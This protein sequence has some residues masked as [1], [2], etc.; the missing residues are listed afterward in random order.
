MK[1]SFQLPASLR[2]ALLGL[3]LFLLPL[4]PR[5]PQLSQAMTGV[6][7]A[8][9]SGSPGQAARLLQV[10]LAY[11]PWR[12]ELWLAAGRYA[13][14][15]GDLQGTV[16]LLEKAVSYQRLSAPDALLLGDAYRQLGK[17]PQAISAWERARQAGADPLEVTQRLLQVHQ[18]Q[19]DLPALTLDLQTLADLQPGNARAQYQ[20]GLSLSAQQPSAAVPYLERA[21]AL[22][23]GLL[24]L[25]QPLRDAIQAALLVDDPAY[26]LVEAGRKLAALEEWRL[27]E[28][29]FQN[30]VQLAPQNGEAWAFLAEARQHLDPPETQLAKQA[31]DRALQASPETVL[32]RILASLYWQRQGDDL[33]AQEH[34]QEALRLEPE[35]PVLYVEI[36][37]L[38]SRQGELSAA[39][40]AFQKAVDLDPRQVSYRRT[41]V[42]FLL[43]HQIELRESALPVARQAVLLAPRDP[44]ALDLMGETLF[45]L[46]DY[47]TAARFVERALQED[48]EYAPALLHLG[49]ISLY[50]GDNTKARLLMTRARDL[51]GDRLTLNQAE[52]LLEYYFP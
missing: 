17:D 10:V 47:H 42:E 32:V 3:L 31:L 9:K 13:A 34:L 14:Q 4:S 37:S 19:D 24:R 38:L 27:A 28:A 26:R 36:G 2:L 8:V 1:K 50:L 12:T 11:E 25:A 7:R 15:A 33:Q 30:A 20:A 41:L 43:H 16:T 51:A 5:P 46:G 29:A 21:A 45:L 40:Q 49:L 23:R 18:A 48:A 52:R 39:R 22:D 35:N 44:A 6:T